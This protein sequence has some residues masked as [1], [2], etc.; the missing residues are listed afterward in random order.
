[1]RRTPWQ[2]LAAALLLVLLAILATLQYRWLGEVSEAE[3]ERM[4]A[5]L[6]TRA[7]ELAQE[8]DAELTRA[9]VTFHVGSDQLDADAAAALAD[10]YARWQASAKIPALVSAVYMADGRM[11]DSAELRRLRSRGARADADRVAA[12]AVGR[13]RPHASGP[14]P[15]RRWSAIGA[16]DAVR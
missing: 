4:R 14:T 10:A 11:L 5:S 8:F 2:L 12:R 16:V 9:Y 7:S 15:G 13:A 6:R 3:R 1:M